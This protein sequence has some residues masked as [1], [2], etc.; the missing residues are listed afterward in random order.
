MGNIN[1]IKID[2]PLFGEVSKYIKRLNLDKLSLSDFNLTL[3]H[4]N[5]D[6]SLTDEVI[7]VLVNEDNTLSYEIVNLM[8]DVTYIESQENVSIKTKLIV[9]GETEYRNN[10]YNK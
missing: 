1:D 10:T 4:T 5:I 8:T 3:K 6:N 7:G 9:L 2:E